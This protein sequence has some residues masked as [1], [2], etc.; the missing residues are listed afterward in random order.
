MKNKNYNAFICIF[1]VYN[2]KYQLGIAR[3][4]LFMKITKV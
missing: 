3:K 1:M 4:Y 2:S